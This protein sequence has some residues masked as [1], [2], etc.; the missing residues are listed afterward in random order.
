MKINKQSLQARAS[1]IAKE[2]GVLPNVVY[3]R[4]FFDAFLS[5][6]A[7]SP[8]K[9][10]FILKGGLY[11]SSLYGI[12]NRATID[13]DFLLTKLAL[14]RESLASSIESICKIDKGDGVAFRI[15]D[16]SPIR[17][18]DLYGGFRLQIQGS[19]ENVRQTFDVDVATGDPIVPSTANYEYQCLVTTEKLTLLAY[20]L[21]SV[22][23]EKMETFLSK[24]LDNSRSKDLY[25]LYI[26]EK[27]EQS[28]M[29]KD[30]AARAF[31]ETC[32]YR[33]FDINM[34]EAKRIVSAIS[35]NVPSKQ[36]WERFAKKS[37]ASNISYEEVMS[38]ITSWVDF[39][40]K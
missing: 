30:D 18:D 34:Q 36:R 10:R 4:F 14:E 28:K 26:L 39:L 37:Y 6:L 15:I 23:A 5:R 22:V 33:H 40:M 29:K 1:F 7:S 27:M 16:I 38:S 11:L 3:A 12:D 21:E 9:D 32:S 19:L 35:V 31:K 2:K 13:I 17:L 8:F 24:G 20:S 25:D